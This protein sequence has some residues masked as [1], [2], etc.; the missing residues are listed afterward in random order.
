MF[1]GGDRG[2]GHRVVLYHL[3]H[4]S[5]FNPFVIRLLMYSSAIDHHR[6]PSWILCAVR[7]RNGG[8]GQPTSGRERESSRSTRMNRLLWR[9]VL[10]SGGNRTY[11]ISQCQCVFHETTISVHCSPRIS[12]RDCTPPAVVP[13]LVAGL[14]NLSHPPREISRGDGI[15]GVACDR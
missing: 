6:C 14:A 4:P 15:S 7:G 8:S 12:G 11:S 2:R 13:G 5:A 3:A 9:T 10:K 1:G